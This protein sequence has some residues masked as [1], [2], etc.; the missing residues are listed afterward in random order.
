MVRTNEQRKRHAAHQ[1]LAAALP[2]VMSALERLEDASETKS[3]VLALDRDQSP[4]SQIGRVGRRSR[5]SATVSSDL[6]G[7]R[8]FAAS[9]RIAK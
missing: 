6:E 9:P 2:M 1:R 7:S 3:R 5:A 4:A 8:S